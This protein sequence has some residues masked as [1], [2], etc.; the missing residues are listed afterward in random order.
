MNGRF[1]TYNAVFRNGL[2]QSGIMRY[3]RKNT[4]FMD[5]NPTRKHISLKQGLIFLVTIFVLFVAYKYTASGIQENK[6]KAVIQERVKA[7]QT[8]Q[9]KT[10]SKTRSEIKAV[11]PQDSSPAGICSAQQEVDAAKE[12]IHACYLRDLLTKECKQLF[13]ING[14]YLT[15]D[16][17]STYF[18][19]GDV[20]TYTYLQNAQI[21][22]CKLP[23]DIAAELNSRAE[24]AQPQCK[25]L[26]IF[27]SQ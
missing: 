27:Q 24:S 3:T 17:D 26:N 6:E 1:H 2:F 22:G 14:Y 23:T 10:S 20:D 15:G 7:Q 16:Y 11:L 18:P 13:D 8:Q 12:W 9:E 4:A 5:T 25:P 21:C 19:D